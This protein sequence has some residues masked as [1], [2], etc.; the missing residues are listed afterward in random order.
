MDAIFEFLAP[1][2]LGNDTTFY[3]DQP[4]LENRFLVFY[5]NKKISF[6]PVRHVVGR[7]QPAY[8]VIFQIDHDQIR[9]EFSD[10][11]VFSNG[12][13]ETFARAAP[14]FVYNHLRG[15]GKVI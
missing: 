11:L 13:L 5:W 14:C 1:E 8:L 2:N 6:L 15:H 10:G 4:F 9:T 12:G 3:K 7:I